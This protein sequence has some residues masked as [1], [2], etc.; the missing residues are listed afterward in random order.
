MK[1]Y[2]N[3]LIIILLLLLIIIPSF[4]KNDHLLPFLSLFDQNEVEETK[5]TLSFVQ[6]KEKENNMITVFLNKTFQLS[7]SSNIKEIEN[8]SDY[9]F[10]SS[11]SLVASIS[12]NGLII[13]KACGKASIKVT[14]KN[15]CNIYDSVIINVINSTNTLKIIK[16]TSTTEPLLLKETRKIPLELGGDIKEDDIEWTS[17]DD[18]IISV[19]NGYCYGK[20]LGKAT[21]KVFSKSN[22]EYFDEITLEIKDDFIRL[23]SPTEL[24][25]NHYYLNKQEITKDRLINQPFEV[26]DEIILN[27]STNATKNSQVYVQSLNENAELLSQDDHTSTLKLIKPGIAYIKISSLYDS[28]ISEI[29]EIRIYDEETKITNFTLSSP[30]LVDDETICQIGEVIKLI[31]LGDNRQIKTKNLEVLISNEKIVKYENGYLIPQNEGET[32]VEIVYLYDQT[33][34][35]TFTIKVKGENEEIIKINH[36]ILSDFSLNKEPFLL[37]TYKEIDVKINDEFS[38]KVDMTPFDGSYFEDLIV[39]T[40]SNQEIT[41]IKEDL[42]FKVKVKF[43]QNELVTLKITHPLYDEEKTINFNVGNIKKDFDFTI[44]TQYKYLGGK[45]YTLKIEETKET[46]DV[47]N[48]TYT[49]SNPNLLTIGTNGDFICYDKGEVIITVSGTLYDKTITK[50][51]KINIDKEYKEYTPVTKM[52][53]QTFIKEDNNLK[54][55]N[56]ENEC[57]NVYQKGYLS[58]TV[59]PNYNNANNYEITTSDKTVIDIIYADNM[60]TLYALQKGKATITIKNY[61]DETLS[62]S[63]DIIVVDV[64]P[65]YYIPILEETNLTLGQEENI[66]FIIDENATYTKTNI[67][68]S[69]NDVV[70]Y[71]NN[72]LIPQNIGETT[73]IIEIVEGNETYKLSLKLNVEKSPKQNLFSYPI[74]EIILFIIIHLIIFYLIGIFIKPYLKIKKQKLII[75]ILIYLTCFFIEFLKLSK[76]EFILVIIIAI[77]NIVSLTLGLITKKEVLHE[78]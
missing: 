4:L 13:P 16:E 64:L 20:A 51:V 24:K 74:Y 41:I 38:F 47:I 27:A 11:N 43:L 15:D 8:T 30:V 14:N 40:T 77:F 23:D 34:K 2:K 53:Y 6:I 72:K 18:N 52:E 60:Y 10:L 66:N 21:I 45:S 71:E 56:F 48:Y 78:N 49:S 65:K 29:L 37:P 62:K 5:S 28:E 57:L 55:I 25:I 69:Q 63:F 54:T 44:K 39:T 61:E 12:S 36:L 32:I 59:S 70:K 17:S 3:L 9:Q 67:S 76:I 26:G 58:I 1:K 33:K 50:E 22:P 35:I 73:M 46:N 7:L 68:F 75:L 31:T 42:S 19:N